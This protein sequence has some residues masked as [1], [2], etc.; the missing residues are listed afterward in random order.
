MLCVQATTNNS[1][2]MTHNKVLQAI[3]GK[4]WGSIPVLFQ[5]DEGKGHE[6]S[7]MISTIVM[8]YHCPAFKGALY[9]LAVNGH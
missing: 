4:N 8:P 9:D 6:G 7:L 3:G 5:A 2:Q 1:Y